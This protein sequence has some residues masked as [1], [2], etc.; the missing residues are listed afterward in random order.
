VQA[1]VKPRTQDRALLVYLAL[2][3]PLGVLFAEIVVIYYSSALGLII[4]SLL[5]QLTFV[6]AAVNWKNG[7]QRFFLVLSLVPVFRI[8][9]LSLPLAGLSTIYWYAVMA[10]PLLL[11]CLYV[12]RILE[13]EL[14]QVGITIGIRRLPHHLLL[15]LGGIAGGIFL[16]Q[17]APPPPAPLPTDYLT[18]GLH[19]LVWIVF[20]AGM[21][22]LIF[23]G[24]ILYGLR[25]LWRRTILSSIYIALIYTILHV[26]HGIG[27]FL[28]VIFGLSFILNLAASAQPRSILG[29]TLAHGL[30]N[31]VY[32]VLL[33]LARL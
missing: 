14:W 26:N 18:L 19:V 24:V 32:F 10:T 33:P 28:V 2:L 3:M 31:V 13:I 17:I 12:M 6:Y 16:Y 1:D 9:G 23:R 7:S 8:L 22:E 20:V 29:T 4:Y 27:T 5:M 15:A 21:E 11:T 25:Q 30:L